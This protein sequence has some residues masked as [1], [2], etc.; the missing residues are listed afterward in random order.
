MAKSP[1]AAEQFIYVGWVDRRTDPWPN[2][3]GIQAGGAAKLDGRDVE[4]LD[5]GHPAWPGM[6]F[7]RGIKPPVVVDGK[8]GRYS[9][10]GIPL[11]DGSG[12]LYVGPT[13]SALCH[14]NSHCNLRKVDKALLFYQK[15]LP[16]SPQPLL[17]RLL[18]QI[19][20]ARSR[21]EPHW[22][23]PI[24]WAEL[25]GIED[26][27]DY[28]VI[29]AA[30]KKWMKREDPFDLR[31]RRRPGTR[32]IVNLSPGTPAMTTCW[33]PLW[34]DGTLGTPRTTVEFVQGDGGLNA[35]D[36]PD[37]PTYD[38]VRVV[39]MDVFAQVKSDAGVGSP[40]RATP[41]GALAAA[42]VESPAGIGV[43]A[44][45]LPGRP[46]DAL[47]QKIDQAAWLGMT[48]I[49]VGDRGTGKTFLAE[50]YHRRRQE[51]R[52]LRGESADS[53]PGLQLERRPLS[54]KSR[55]RG[56][57]FPG[58]SPANP[59]RPVT[60]TL[61]EYA[62]LNKLRFNLFG[63]ARGAFT[64]VGAEQ[65]YDGLLGE[66]HGGTLFL[67]E[68]HHLDKGLQPLLLGPLNT[69]GLNVRRYTPETAAYVIVS[70]FDLVLATNDRQWRDRIIPDLQDRVERVVLQVPS[71]RDFQRD[72]PQ[73]I[74]SFW[75]YTMEQRCRACRIQYTQAGEWG[76][77]RQLLEELF[78]SNPLKG[79]WRDL[80]RLS[81]YILMNLVD[82]RGGRPTDL[83]WSTGG[84]RDAI[85]EAFGTS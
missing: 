21:D 5:M 31:A 22:A 45:E 63:W 66:A 4:F 80:Q 2:H 36:V 78:Q 7:V 29:L 8:M 61:S 71:F 65:A 58:E 53:P 83:C 73:T 25:E 69:S 67:D 55:T 27:T 57:F 68:F 20:K 47:R 70:I 64:G 13:L 34:W 6:P 44:E 82:T 19:Q 46:Y 49:L 59:E 32:I 42:A 33:L 84:L 23:K 48:I 81:D 12:R 30:I 40:P 62:D 10:P 17:Q 39:S 52:R 18:E 9:W 16:G 1:E 50:Y 76:Q 75:T 85:A 28:G 24:L 54:A 51:Y 38:P 56:M 74:W 14:E 77:C 43:A 11:A 72:S 15:G 79:N 26:P 60:V 37:D 41:E 3:E 35:R